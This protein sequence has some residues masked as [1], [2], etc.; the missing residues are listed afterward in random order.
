MVSLWDGFRQPKVNLK[1]IF[2]TNPVL[3]QS[4]Y[5]LSL[6]LHLNCQADKEI[7]CN[8]AVW[9]HYKVK[10][11]YRKLEVLER[12]QPECIPPQCHCQPNTAPSPE[13]LSS[14]VWGGWRVFPQG[15]TGTPL[16]S[17]LKGN[18]N[19][20]SNSVCNNKNWKPPTYQLVA[21]WTNQMWH[22]YTMEYYIIQ[23]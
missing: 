1:K 4:K 10:V 22:I 6:F 5:L 23:L 18:K 15:P 16:Y 11:L 3:N 12:W 8:R 7:S 19:V 13:P 2:P 21:K 14:L 20:H 9:C 17:H